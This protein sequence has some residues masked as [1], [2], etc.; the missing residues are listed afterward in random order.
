M[1]DT[2]RN[3]QNQKANREILT[4]APNNGAAQ[5]CQATPQSG[6]I[7]ISTNSTQSNQNSSGYRHNSQQQL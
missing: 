3:Q 1:P 2:L 5:G 7:E 6:G 4:N